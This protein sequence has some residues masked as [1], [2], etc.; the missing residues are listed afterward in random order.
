[1]IVSCSA[2]S[3]DTDG[4]RCFGKRALCSANSDDRY[5]GIEDELAFKAGNLIGITAGTAHCAH[6]FEAPGFILH[7]DVKAILPW[8]SRVNE[9]RAGW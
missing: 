3:A 5:V 2:S 1:M 7:A 6:R 9:A 8:S 4:G